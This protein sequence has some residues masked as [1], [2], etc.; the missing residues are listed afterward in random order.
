M[1]E[2]L[3]KKWGNILKEKKRSAHIKRSFAMGE[4][5]YNLYHRHTFITT[6]DNTNTKNFL[7]LKTST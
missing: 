6:E 2:V 1:T 3:A 7:C 5:N 4:E